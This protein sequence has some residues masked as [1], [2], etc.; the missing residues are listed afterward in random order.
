MISIITFL[1]YFIL[2]YGCKYSGF[3]KFHE[4]FLN[5]KK[6][7]ALKGFSSL[8]IILGHLCTHCPDYAKNLIQ[9][10]YGRISIYPAFFFF[11]LD[12]G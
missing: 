9:T 6:M 2:F 3:K 4:D 1:Y 11:V 12:M 5:I 7:N 10:P 8:S